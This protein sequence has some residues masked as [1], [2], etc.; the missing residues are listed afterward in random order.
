L[1]GPLD[2]IASSDHPWS[3]QRM[4]NNGRIDKLVVIVVNAATSPKAE[5][6][7]SATVPASSTR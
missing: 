4:I 7:Q 3:V 1:R 6:D 5:R 2:A